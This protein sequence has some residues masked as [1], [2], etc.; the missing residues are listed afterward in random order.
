[1]EQFEEEH[2]LILFGRDDEIHRIRCL[3]RAQEAK[4]CPF[5][6]IS[7][8][9]GIGKSSLAR[10]GIIPDV[11][12]SVEDSRFGKW[13]SFAI[14]PSQ[15]GKYPLVGLVKELC[16]EK[17]LR[18]FSQWE[19]ELL[20][21]IG[22]TQDEFKTLLKTRIIDSLK[23][24]GGDGPADRL[25]LLLDQME[26][27]FSDES[28]SDEKREGFFS[29]I[30]KLVR[31]GYVWVIATVRSDFYEHCQKVRALVSLKEEGGSFDLSIP[32]MNS[33]P[34]IITEPAKLAGLS[35]ETRNGVKLSNVIF[36]EASQHKELLPLLE[37][38][39]LELC[40]RRTQ[41]GKLTFNAFE[42]L[43]GVEG[44]L[45]ERC[46]STYRALSE[47]AKETLDDV[48]SELVTLSGDGK[49]A[50]V[51]RTVSKEVFDADPAQKELVKA[52]EQARLFTASNGPDG[53]GV[54]TVVHEALLRVW[55]RAAQMVERF[56][57]FIKTRAEVVRLQGFWDAEGRLEI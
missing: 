8:P 22:H 31:S 20:D 50:I 19:S 26:E 34:E 6:L 54:V 4:G 3:L 40:E 48:L 18:G 55:P 16:K 47:K 49:D 7:G 39:L 24:S 45:R 27:L 17:T 2:S 10:A 35:F 36:E 38:L 43:G 5:L 52:M 30:E 53:K 14:K 15:L 21:S 46:E 56:R 11:R 32:T 42:A 1:L 41:E 44:S 37:H 28:I 9:S 13:R 12:R 33:L 23:I 57:A 25:I 51:R 29:A